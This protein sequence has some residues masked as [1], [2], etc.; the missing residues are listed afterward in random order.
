MTMPLRRYSSRTPVWGSLFQ[1]LCLL[2]VLSA[3]STPA[4]AQESGKRVFVDEVRAIELSQTT[5]VLGRLVARRQGEVAARING[6][7]ESFLVQIGDRLETGQI[8]A[9]IDDRRLKAQR[10]L[11]AS[12]LGE[13]K[14]EL[15]TRQEEL[16]LSR[17]DFA[18][19]EKLKSSSAFS[20]A[21]FEDARQ[22]VAIDRAEMAEAQART[23]SAEADLQLAEIDLYNA[24]VR[25]PYAGVVTARMAESGVYLQ[26]GAPVVRL[27]ADR[28]LEIEAD[29]PFQQLTGLTPDRSLRFTLEDGTVHDAYLRSILPDENPLTRTR[30]VRFSPHFDE[31]QI[32]L[33]DGQSVSLALP[34][35]DQAP[36]LT[37]HKDAVIKRGAQNIVFVAGPVGAE[38]RNVRLGRAVGDRFQVLD[39][40]SAGDK[41][42]VRGNERLMP[43]DKVLVE[44][45]S[46]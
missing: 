5:E 31:P 10:D 30:I 12:H 1:L 22:A 7:V 45:A 13:A 25:A 18:R 21:R 37:V 17:L 19:Q 8:I 9:T 33:A 28:D 44:E 39:G 14:A 43:G 15:A 35:G 11:A 38:P 4:I 2:L 32:A 6:P 34:V 46:R 3:G 40:L 42:I 16:R 23:A 27:I 29:I 20:Q 41:A 36:A 24:K 26:T